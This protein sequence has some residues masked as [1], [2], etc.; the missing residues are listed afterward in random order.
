M[1]GNLKKCARVLAV[2]FWLV[3]CGNSFAQEDASL[4]NEWLLKKKFE[5]MDARDKAV[6][7]I[8]RYEEAIRKC[9]DTISNSE[10][11]IKLAREQGK[12]SAEAIARTALN[13]AQEAKSGNIEKKNALEFNKMRVERD[14]AYLDKAMAEALANPRKLQSMV[15][16]NSGR[17]S[18]KKKNG[19]DIPFE[20][21]R[22]GLLE[23]GDELTTQAKSSAELQFL[24][25]RGTLK[26]GEKTR[27]KMEKDDG[28][29]QVMALAE[30]KV[31]VGVE[32]LE[33]YQERLEE[34]LK[35]SRNPKERSSLERMLIK[36]KVTILK[37][38]RK[39]EVRTPS[40]AMS[41]RG[42][43]FLVYVNDQAGTEV[44]V[45][46]GAVELKNANEGKT[47]VVESGYR[48]VS[49]KDGRLPEPE[50]IDLSKYG[51]WEGE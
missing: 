41:I 43:R 1:T 40:F 9:D 22:I 23:T 11:I 15:V 21:N 48:V 19:D 39:L 47:V 8:K 24:D 14:L 49:T 29:T 5:L 44:I 46:E 28:E 4:D 50:K 3:C 33:E 32:K 17:V 30:G 18:I 16:N 51:K 7:E 20:S 2:L 31:S 35:Y 45:L 10:S 13:K 12:A 27:L 37:K 6:E 38:L 26:V 25:G 42:T 34:R 36:L